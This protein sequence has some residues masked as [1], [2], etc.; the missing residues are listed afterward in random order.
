MLQGKTGIAKFRLLGICPASGPL[1]LGFIPQFPR[2]L[3]WNTQRKTTFPKSVNIKN[4]KNENK[5][6]GFMFFFEKNLTEK[7]NRAIVIFVTINH[8]EKP[9]I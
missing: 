5:Q 8:Y 3:H 1:L 9:L 2:A 4:K 7:E 6:L